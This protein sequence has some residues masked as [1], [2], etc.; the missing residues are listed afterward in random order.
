MIKPLSNG[1]KAI[2]ISVEDSAIDKDATDMKALTEGLSKDPEAWRELAKFREGHGPTKFVIGAIPPDDLVLMQSEL[3][4]SVGTS[5]AAAF[6]RVAWRCFLYGLRDIENID[7]KVT[8]RDVDGI[9]Y[10]SPSWLRDN[11][12]RGMIE[13]GTE[14][15][16]RIWQWNQLTE[17]DAK[18]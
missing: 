6:K 11:F 18:N 3:T 7:A 8:K 15:G 4:A 16:A 10:V 5:F 13:I 14:I 17:D 12:N 9:E 2:T 1:S